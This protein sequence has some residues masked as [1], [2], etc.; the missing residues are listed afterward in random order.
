MPV[1]I[2]KLLPENGMESGTSSFGTRPVIEFA[3]F[4]L[5]PQ[6]R[7]LSTL[8]GTPLAL[9]SRAFDTLLALVEHRGEVLSRQQLMTTV[10]PR[11]VVEENNLNQAIS[12]LRKTLG[13]SDTNR[14]I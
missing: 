2:N 7:K 4:R 1:K 9:N 14:I 8:D 13:D 10:W 3:N 6:Q 11:A 12:V 5:D